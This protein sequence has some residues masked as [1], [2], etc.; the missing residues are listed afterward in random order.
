MWRCGRKDKKNPPVLH[1]PMPREATLSG[2]ADARGER[3][4]ARFLD[5][6]QCER[7]PLRIEQ[8]EQ[9]V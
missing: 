8:L 1:A 9:T 3:L 5:S 4:Q 2:F 7:Y 6:K